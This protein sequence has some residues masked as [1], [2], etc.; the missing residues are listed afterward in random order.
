MHRY[1]NLW[2]AVF[3][4][5]GPGVGIYEVRLSSEP[6]VKLTRP[7]LVLDGPKLGIDPLIGM[8]FSADGKSLI[9]VKQRGGDRP[10]TIGVI[11]NWYEEFMDRQ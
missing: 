7:R 1:F 8:D 3:Q 5:V 4:P 2:T 10:A 11:E 9:V 6:R